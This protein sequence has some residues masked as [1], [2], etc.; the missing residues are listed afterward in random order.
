MS[1]QTKNKL[2]ILLVVSYI[3]S[4]AYESMFNLNINL[5]IVIL[6]I[7][8]LLIFYPFLIGKKEIRKPNLFDILILIFILY[9]FIHFYLGSSL[10]AIINLLFGS[11]IAF[12]IGKN[13]DLIGYKAF[14]VKV[15]NL[16]SYVLF[17]FIINNYLNATYQYRITVGDAHPVAIGELIGIFLIVN[18]WGR[19]GKTSLL[20]RLISIIIGIVL[21]VF[22]VGSRGAFFAVLI[23][24]LLIYFIKSNLKNKIRII[25]LSIGVYFIYSSITTNTIITEK[26]PT[27]SRFSFDNILN[28]PSIT[29]SNEYLGRVDFYRESLSLFKNNPL[30]GIGVSEIYSHNLFLEL[31]ATTGLIGFSIMAI[32]FIY[33]I[34]LGTRGI[35]KISKDGDLFITIFSIMVFLL[36]YRQTSFTL[37]TSK[38]LF[39]MAGLLSNLGQWKSLINR[40]RIYN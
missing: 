12:F 3:Y 18:I 7:L 23:S 17:F 40:N 10:N 22:I 8:S 21:M 13:T 33:L 19:E 38:S 5:T 29:G 15:I 14:F 32:F 16:Y 20:L 4:Y 28:D 2:I 31:L 11:I 35:L 9:I 6:G 25:L 26:Y 24:I 27:I 30:T 36:I 1:I 39:L 34:K 37:A